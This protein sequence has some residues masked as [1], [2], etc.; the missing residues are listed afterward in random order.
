MNFLVA[1][2]AFIDGKWYFEGEH[3]SFETNVSSKV[4]VPLDD[5]PLEDET[6]EVCVPSDLDPPKKL[7]R[8][9]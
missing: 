8:R 6:S 1:Q 3:V 4:F 9:R 2:D 7:K 5:K